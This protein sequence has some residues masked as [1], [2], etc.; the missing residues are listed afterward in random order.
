MNNC[1]LHSY[2]KSWGLLLCKSLSFASHLFLLVLVKM[3]VRLVNRF[4]LT[5][6][7]WC[8][9]GYCSSPPHLDRNL[10]GV[11]PGH[12]QAVLSDDITFT[13]SG[14]HLLDV[15]K[16]PKPHLSSSLARYSSRP[17]PGIL[18]S[19]MWCRWYLF[20]APLGKCTTR[21]HHHYYH[22]YDSSNWV[23]VPSSV[24]CLI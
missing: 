17:W 15:G 18:R 7:C 9:L 21:K 16:L 10:A 5:V 11:D 6:L 4:C 19:Q 3:T 8:C 12:Q 1:Q 22:Y 2:W 24:A 20:L 23:P 14:S 13:R